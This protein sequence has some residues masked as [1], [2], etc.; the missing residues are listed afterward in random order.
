MNHKILNKKIKIKIIYLDVPSFKASK[1]YFGLAWWFRWLRICLQ[2]GR[3]R[4]D[5]WMG[6]IPWRR[7]W[8]PTQIFL[9]RKAYGQRSLVGSSPRHPKES[10][11]TEQLTHVVW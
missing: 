11:T 2:C 1:K 4:F 8:Q 7:K 5:P 10:D 3:P 9:P 6:K